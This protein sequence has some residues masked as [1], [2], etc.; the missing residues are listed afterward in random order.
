MNIPILRPHSL[1]SQDQSVGRSP[2]TREQQHI[3]CMNSLAI[4]E[5]V[6]E[7]APGM[8]PQLFDQLM[9]EMEGVQNI[10]VFLS[11]PHNW[12]PSSL[13]IKL[14]SNAN[15]IFNNADTAYHIG[16]NSILKQR[17]GYIQ[18]IFIYS[19]GNPSHVIKKLQKINDHFN[20]TKTV[21]TVS[22][23]KTSAIIRL[24]W[25]K[26]IPTNRDFCYFNKGI[27]QAIP[28]IWRC[29]PAE[30]IETQNFFDGDEYCEYHLK[31]QPPS[32]MRSFLF[33]LITPGRVIRETIQELERDKELLKEKYHNIN[34]L[35]RRLERKVA[36][37]TTLQESS[38]A[39]LST[40]NLEDLLDVIVSKLVD[41]ADLDRACIFLANEKNESLILIH[42][43]GIDKKLISQFK[44]YEIPLDKVDNII[45]RSAHSKDPIVVEN[46]E[47]LSLN[48]DN[49]LIKTLHPKAF[50]LVPLNVRGEIIGIMVG[51]N[52]KN[53]NFVHRADKNFLKGFANHIAMALDNANLYKQLR[54]SEERYREIVENVNEGIWVL[55]KDGNIQFANRRLVD[56]LGHGDLTGVN[57]SQL[58]KKDDEELLR[59]SIEDNLKGQL[60]KQ[61]VQL[62]NAGGE[63]K[64]VL[65]SSVPI[66]HE[67][68]F[69]RCLAIVTDL[70]EKKHMEK[71]LLQTQKLE[72]IG[73]MAGG[74]AHDFNNILTGILGYTAMLQIGL[75]DNSKLQKYTDIIEKSSLRA[76]DLV[77]KMLAFSRHSN[78]APNASTSLEVIIADSL[79]LMQ[80]SLPQTIEIKVCQS[81]DLP[82]VKCDSTE[83]Q[84]IILNLCL[85]ASDAMPDG[86]SITIATDLIPKT[87]IRQLQ[88]ELKI[89]LGEYALLQVADT[90][91][92]MS[93]EVQER[94]F[95]PFYTTKEVGKGSGLG[96]AM[97]YGIMQGIGGAILVESS[98][99]D[100]TIFKL[101][102]PVAQEE[103]MLDEFFPDENGPSSKQAPEITSSQKPV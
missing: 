83:L 69:S 59:Q 75:A 64:T 4:I 29:P 27:Y 96:L 71:K 50:I 49:P 74:I 35:N 87:E 98:Y 20:R 5:Y 7:K 10:E 19:L 45:A 56:L 73:T 95:D 102:F 85:N 15:H 39:I 86:G 23:T 103:N 22:L 100:G 18:K 11:D 13:M 8:L 32:R 16:F 90:G 9:P 72:A 30:L 55:D 38:A 66:K 3:N 60:S 84:Q 31:W 17:F 52:S 62:E 47:A 68:S 65:L 54:E 63:Y 77:K 33:K 94:I 48:P 44:G 81:D 42:A 88:S 53:Q 93:E 46:V 36:E 57:I 37:M 91:T 24:H 97:V 101:Y 43:V 89:D 76:S 25:D 26:S 12:I 21:E 41:V 1:N 70:T 40:L 82:L 34:T 79:S 92:G 28:T 51:D 2:F 78:P 58:V 14:F 99:G 6:R 61:E 80:S 67:G